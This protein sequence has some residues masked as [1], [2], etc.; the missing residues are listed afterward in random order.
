MRNDVKIF[1]WTD[2]YD[3]KYEQEQ[4]N[5]VIEHER[6]RCIQSHVA[7]TIYAQFAQERNI[8]LN[9][10]LNE[11]FHEKQTHHVNYWRRHDVYEQNKRWHFAEFVDFFHFLFFYNTDILKLLKR[12]RYKII[13]IEFV[14]DINILIYETSTKNNCKALKKFTLNASYEQDDMKHASR[15]LN[16][17]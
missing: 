3:L 14:N 16:M 6:R 17:N 10:N 4:N 13:V 9:N 15:R 2:L 8:W 12:S 1:H 7:K 11:Q 5:Y